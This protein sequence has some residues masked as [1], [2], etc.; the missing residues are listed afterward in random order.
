M[1]RT[2]DDV[3]A[4]IERELEKANSDAAHRHAPALDH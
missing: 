4:L 1:Y 2:W 3:E